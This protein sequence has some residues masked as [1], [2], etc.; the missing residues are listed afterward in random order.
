MYSTHKE[1]INADQ[2]LLPGQYA[3]LSAQRLGDQRPAMLTAV[4]LPQLLAV[5]YTRKGSSEPNGPCLSQRARST[6]DWIAGLRPPTVFE[7]AAE[8]RSR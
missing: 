3:S 1:R 2:A 5:A 7:H 4:S 8:G 6:W